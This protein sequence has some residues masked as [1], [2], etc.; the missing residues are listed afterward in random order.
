MTSAATNP[1]NP[2]V[3]TLRI[4]E[5]IGAVHRIL[6]QHGITMSPA[7]VNKLVRRFSFEA[8]AHGCSFAD[9]LL[10]RVALS[11]DCRRQLLRD[12]DL[13]RVTAYF[14][15]TGQEATYRVIRQRGF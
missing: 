7:K 11:D 1:R 13:E 3:T 4:Q 10:E 15:P 9:Y 12:P 6:D 8:A 5:A 14:D 2:G